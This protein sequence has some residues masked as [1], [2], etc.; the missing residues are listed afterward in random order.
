MFDTYKAGIE[1]L[2]GHKRYPGCI[3]VN[4]T[5]TANEV[6]NN[7]TVGFKN[8]RFNMGIVDAFLITSR[9]YTESL[10]LSFFEYNAIKVNNKIKPNLFLTEFKD[11]ADARKRIKLLTEKPLVFRGHGSAAA[12][13]ANNT[14]Y[15]EA[16]QGL[17]ILTTAMGYESLNIKDLKK[18]FHFRAFNENPEY[19]LQLFNH[20]QSLTLGTFIKTGAAAVNI[21]KLNKNNGLT[22]MSDITLGLGKDVRETFNFLNKEHKFKN[23]NSYFPADILIYNPSVSSKIRSAKSLTEFSKIFDSDDVV[24]IS[25]KMNSG[26]R[27]FSSKVETSAEKQIKIKSYAARVVSGT[28]IVHIIYTRGN[29]TEEVSLTFKNF[30]TD[31]YAGF[32]TQYKHWAAFEYPDIEALEYIKDDMDKINRNSNTT[33]VIGKAADG[34]RYFL[35]TIKNIEFDYSN[36]KI[37]PVLW[38]RLLENEKLKPLIPNLE[39]ETKKVYSKNKY[40]NYYKKMNTL[41]K[42]NSVQQLFIAWLLA[43]NKLT[44]MTIE[45]YLIYTIMASMKENY[46]DMN[47]YPKYYRIS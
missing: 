46:G 35:K 13:R 14:P 25:L 6:V 16:A 19:V 43:F 10:K 36:I 29:N 15:Q 7:F 1:I 40:I 34:L 23:I 28:I 41:I 31:K 42:V 8:G 4:M 47:Y 20:D 38:E 11:P 21:K 24:A 22:D 45:D 39:L 12:M 18:I 37:T 5:A 27:R 17:N 9:T 2:D 44:D 32:E 33:A 26:Y 30:G 3:V